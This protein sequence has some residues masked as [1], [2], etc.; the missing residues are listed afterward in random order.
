MRT[1][2]VRFSLALLLEFVALRPTL[3]QVCAHGVEAGQIV[4]F[5]GNTAA[6]LF[7]PPITEVTLYTTEALRSATF[8]SETRVSAGAQQ[9][10]TKCSKAHVPRFSLNWTGQRPPLPEDRSQRTSSRAYRGSILIDFRDASAPYDERQRTYEY[11]HYDP[12]LNTI[13]L[14]GRCP[15]GGTFGFPC[16]NNRPGAPIRWDTPGLLEKVL[17]HEIG[18]GL[19]LGHDSPGDACAGG[20]MQETTAPGEVLTLRSD[21]CDLADRM[22]DINNPC[23]YAEQTAPGEVHP[24][25]TDAVPTHGGVG[26]PGGAGTGMAGLFCEEYPWLCRTRPPWGGSGILCEWAC[27]TTS[28]DF[29]DSSTDCSWAC[30]GAPTSPGTETTVDPV[31]G[32]GPRIGLKVPDRGATM[33]GVVTVLGFAVDLSGAATVSFGIDGTEV[34]LQQFASG[35]RDDDACRAPLGIVHYL[36][37]PFAGFSGRLDTQAFANGPHTLEVVATDPQGWT[38]SVE[39]PIVINNPTCET[40][41]PTI[42]LTAPANGATVSGTVPLAATASDNVGVSVVKFYADGSLL[43]SD[44]TSPYTGSWNAAAAT[45]GSHTLQARAWD[46]C[47]NTRWSNLVT[48]NV[49]LPPPV[50]ADLALFLAFDGS[51]VARGA[52]VSLPPTQPLVSTSTRFRIA[53]TGGEA[54]TLANPTALVSDPCFELAEVPLSPVAPAGETFFRVRLYCAQVGVRSTAVTILSNDPDESPYSFTVTGLVASPTPPEIAVSRAIDGLAIPDGGST[55]IG[56]TPVGVSTSV[57]YRIANTGTGNLDLANPAGL[58]SGACFQQI[59]TPVTPI[60]PGGAAF[61]RVRLLCPAAGTANGTVTILSNDADESPYDVAL[62]GTVT[63]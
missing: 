6:E 63:P 21:Y 7:D 44:T 37:R 47:A 34:A 5:L 13:I 58:V 46:A 19:G 56:P 41:Q 33:S 22:N 45:A 51:P 48:V 15:V 2:F 23:T 53:N 35:F 61:F 42:S 10:N 60:P 59:E 16:V 9:W 1:A 62:V 3:A 52:T 24:C 20:I 12:D 39:T 14:W 30:R 31:R 40:V 57:R 32:A 28:F 38:T 4:P 50:P 17:A 43:G 25:D 18:H 55:S 26:G 27:V 36:C 29:G 49:P 54:L 8:I 11:G